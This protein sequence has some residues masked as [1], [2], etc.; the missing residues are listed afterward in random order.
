MSATLNSNVCNPYNDKGN[1]P[2][3]EQHNEYRLI[4]LEEARRIKDKNY[5][6][7]KQQEEEIINKQMEQLKEKSEYNDKLDEI[8]REK[9]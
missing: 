3:N 9:K 7:R 6:L 8:R 4:Y 2:E 1:E 5:I